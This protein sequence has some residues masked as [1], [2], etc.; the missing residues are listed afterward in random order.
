M[1]PIARSS[2]PQKGARASVDLPF[3]SNSGVLRAPAPRPGWLLLP[4]L[5]FVI[6]LICQGVASGAT[7]VTTR[8]PSRY[9]VAH[10]G[11]PPAPP[12]TVTATADLRATAALVAL[13]SAGTQLAGT[14]GVGGTPSALAACL[15]AGCRDRYISANPLGLVLHDYA[16]RVTLLVAQ[17]LA[18]PG[19][20][21]GFLVEIA[22][23]A[24][25]GWVVGRAYVATGTTTR[26]AG[27]TITLEI[28]LNLATATAPTILNVDTV[29]D[30]C[31]S[32]TVCP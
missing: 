13:T 22:V 21:K 25:T 17:P 29:V 24:S 16:E 12:A 9:S 11:A 10:T 30:T 8:V 27:A 15:A 18:P 3:R 4:S 6:I 19:A 23:H 32:A 31:T 2:G 14:N 26:A 1:H 7:S 20:S 28:F 5:L